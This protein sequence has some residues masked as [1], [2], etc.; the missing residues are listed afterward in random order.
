[1]KNGF[2]VI[3]LLLFICSCSDKREKIG[4]DIYLKIVQYQ[5]TNGRLPDKLND[6]GIEETMEGPIYYH[7]QTDSTF[8]IYYGGGLGE[9]IVYDPKTKKWE[10]DRQ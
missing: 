3:F 10:S 7:K 4:E 2:I 8:I 5:K 1:M 6:I 9:S